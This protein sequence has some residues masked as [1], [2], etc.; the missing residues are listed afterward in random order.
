MI[1]DTDHRKRLIIELIKISVK[2]GRTE[3]LN[4]ILTKVSR[5]RF[6]HWNWEQVLQIIRQYYIEQQQPQ[7]EHER[8]EAELVADMRLI[9]LKQNY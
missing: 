6:K 3:S 8:D 1:Q 5:D 2:T 4:K 7:N 9:E